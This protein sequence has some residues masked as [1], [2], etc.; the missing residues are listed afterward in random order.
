MDVN[1]QAEE[2]RLRL[3]MS[4]FGDDI[5]RRFHHRLKD[6]FAQIGQKADM[7]DLSEDIGS[8]CFERA[9]EEWSPA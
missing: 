4:I 8:E 1:E 2:Q 5:D 3:A 9:K 6:A 7:A